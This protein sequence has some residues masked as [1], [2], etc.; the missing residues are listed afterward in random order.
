MQ[1]RKLVKSPGGRRAGIMIEIITLLSWH[2][3][4][5][6]NVGM[7]S[8]YASLSPH[9]IRHNMKVVKII[10][11]KEISKLSTELDCVSDIIG[12]SRCISMHF[13]LIVINKH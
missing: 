8:N 11:F 7:L 6:F 10:W 13:L 9:F 4:V 2:I 1:M 3:L 12:K 5:Y